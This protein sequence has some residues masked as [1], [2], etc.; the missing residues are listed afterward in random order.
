MK[1]NMWQ[2][3]SVRVEIFRHLK[4]QKLSGNIIMKTYIYNFYILKLHFY[5]VK[6]GFT[7]V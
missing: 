4:K 3:M 5:I 7:G 6:L 2:V 1:L